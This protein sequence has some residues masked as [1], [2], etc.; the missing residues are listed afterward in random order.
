MDTQP[1]QG[2][3]PSLRRAAVIT[4]ELDGQPVTLVSLHLKSGCFSAKEDASSKE[5][6]V[7]ACASAHRQHKILADWVAG[8]QRAGVSF[9]LLGDFNRHLDQ[10][11]DQLMEQLKAASPG[12]VV[13]AVG[14]MKG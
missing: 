11:S 9:I 6:P 12:T 10:P 1:R 5:R 13:K 14:G 4:A 2:C 8:R 3:G 7:K